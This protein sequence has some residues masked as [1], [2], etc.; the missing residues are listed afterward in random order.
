MIGP[1]APALVAVGLGLSVGLAMGRVARRVA[2]ADRRRQGAAPPASSVGVA[3]LAVEVVAVV[4]ALT[5]L[6]RF[7]PSWPLAPYPVVVT[8]AL[9]S[10]LTD[11][12]HRRIPDRIVFPAL[13]LCAGAM[14]LAALGAGQPEL[15]WSAAAGAG[16]Y[17]GVLLMVHLV[18]P[19]GMGRGDVKLALLLG[20]AVGWLHP[21]SIATVEL[22][23]VALSG[24]SGL[25]LVLA[26]AAA[27]DRRRR[28]GEA[29]GP[30]R[31]LRIPF[32]PAMSV[33][34]LGVV[35]F[36]DRLVA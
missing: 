23:V 33:A 24:A 30:I 9:A 26:L 16:L 11:L 29:D 31:Q 21:I 7:G 34:A 10:T 22:V 5:L 32:G 3:T 19:R 6:V 28:P 36:G 27:L 14:A 20:A 25:G 2:D 18:T 1:A 12:R 35:L 13:A 8:A 15:L 17:A 4:V